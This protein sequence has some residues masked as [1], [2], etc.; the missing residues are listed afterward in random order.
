MCKAG[1]QNRAVNLGNHK[2]AEGAALAVARYLR[3]QEEAEP[4]LLSVH[5]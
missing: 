1:K 2:S 4:D 5:H 3:R